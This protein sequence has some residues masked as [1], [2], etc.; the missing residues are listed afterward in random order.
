MWVSGM[1]E[2]NVSPYESKTLTHSR[3]VVS[4]AFQGEHTLSFYYLENL[5]HKNEGNGLGYDIHDLTDSFNVQGSTRDR[6]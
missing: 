2:P 6:N 1:E 4:H 3:L 5:A